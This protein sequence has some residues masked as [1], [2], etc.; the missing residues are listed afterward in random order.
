MVNVH[1]TW[2]LS[3]QDSGLILMPCPGTK[4]P[5]LKQTLT[6]LSEQG[7]VAIVSAITDEEFEKVSLTG[8]G[9]SV[10]QQGIHWFHLPVEDDSVPDD[11]FERKWQSL[12]AEI[13]SKLR[14]GKVAL[15]CMGGSG[16]TGLLAG[17]VLLELE[18]PVEVIINEV[19]QLRP[20]AF[21]KE[22]QRNYLSGIAGK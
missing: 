11:S 17:R 19:K 16:R 15:H 10:Q 7:V 22:V 9:E 1:P 12:G 21:S 13:V 4:G 3:V 2:E 5:D 6:Q 18:W 20:N 8:F 14:E